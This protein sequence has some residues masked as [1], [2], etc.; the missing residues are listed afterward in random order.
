MIIMPRLNKLLR[1]S[2]GVGLFFVMQFSG[3]SCTGQEIEQSDVEEFTQVDDY[4]DSLKLGDL[5]LYD[6]QVPYWYDR[7]AITADQAMSAVEI[8][9]VDSQAFAIRAHISQFAIESAHSQFHMD[10]I[11]N[12]ANQIFHSLQVIDAK[13]KYVAPLSLYEADFRFDWASGIVN[14]DSGTKLFAISLALIVLEE[15]AKIYRQWQIDHANN[16]TV[17][18]GD[19]QNNTARGPRVEMPKTAIYRRDRVINELKEELDSLLASDD[20][21][22]EHLINLRNLFETNNARPSTLK[23]FQ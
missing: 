7:E 12:K 10:E 1:A 14:I 16:S 20:I 2:A 22:P 11:F 17:V 23:Y 8:L 6:L 19:P 4:F 15:D 3:S 18:I 9:V 21:L 5:P 13:Y